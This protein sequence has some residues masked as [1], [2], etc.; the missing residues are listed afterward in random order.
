MESAVVTMFFVCKYLVA[1]FALAGICEYIIYPIYDHW[2]DIC[3]FLRGEVRC[4]R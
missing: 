1:F 2:Q 4:K 3:K